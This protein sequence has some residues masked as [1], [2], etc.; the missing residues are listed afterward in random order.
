MTT[1]SARISLRTSL[2][3]K[4]LIERAAAMMGTTVSGFMLQNAY[5]AARRI[6]ADNDTLLLSQQAFEAFVTACENPEEPNEALRALM[7]RR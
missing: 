5:E 7:A 1:E 6:V 3:A 2:E 4:A